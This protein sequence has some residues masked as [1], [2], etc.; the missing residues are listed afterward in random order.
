[1]TPSPSQT[2]ALITHALSAR[3]HAYAPYSH[4]SVGAAVM[5][6]DG[7]I[8]SGCNVENA[9]YPAGLCAERCAVGAAVAAGVR[10]FL[11]IAVVGSGEDYT[12]PCGICRQVLQ[13]FGV[14]LVICAKTTEDYSIIQGET[15]LPHAFGAA[16]LK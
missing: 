13:E 11:A 3:A 2:K 9:S 12:T 7:R 1:M 5:A 16:S 10:D 4:F 8:F 6:A 14:P 15:L